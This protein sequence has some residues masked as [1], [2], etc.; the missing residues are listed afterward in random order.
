M[1]I[2][3]AERTIIKESIKL[4]ST[5][6]RPPNRDRHVVDSSV[7]FYYTVAGK[8]CQLRGSSFCFSTHA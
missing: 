1:G 6:D 2:V 4:E 8:D 3:D 7:L 5:V